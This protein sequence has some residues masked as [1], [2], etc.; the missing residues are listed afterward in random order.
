LRETLLRM[1]R[2]Y[3]QEK[4]TKLQKAK[5]LKNNKKRFFELAIKYQQKQLNSIELKELQ[6]WNIY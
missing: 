6:A 1:N 2:E 4:I 5:T 3:F